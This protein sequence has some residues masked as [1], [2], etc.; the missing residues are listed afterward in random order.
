MSTEIQRTRYLEGRCHLLALALQDATGGDLVVLAS[1]NDRDELVHVGVL[2]NG[3]ILD[4]N[5]ASTPDAWHGYWNEDAQEN[6]C[7]MSQRPRE[8]VMDM[9]SHVANSPAE[10]RSAADF[11]MTVLTEVRAQDAKD[12]KAIARGPSHATDDGVTMTAQDR[13]RS[14]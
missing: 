5:G 2:H 4:A 13:G 12:Y 9:M 14:I 8:E 10:T 6:G 11:A 1:M 3:R 7:S